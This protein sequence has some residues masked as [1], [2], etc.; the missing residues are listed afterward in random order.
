[1]PISAQLR[2]FGKIHT[3]SLLA[4]LLEEGWLE[5]RPSVWE[6]YTAKTEALL[7]QF[8]KLPDYQNAISGNT[9]INC[10]DHWAQELIETGYLHN[11]A[12]MWFSSIWI[13][14]LKLPW[15]LGA[16]FF[17][18]HLLDG[19]PA[20]N[21]LSWRWTAGL[22]T[23]GKHYIARAENIEKFT[24]GKF[25]PIGQLNE[26]PEAIV[27]NFE[28]PKPIWHKSQ[29]VEKPAHAV[30]LIITEE[31]V[32]P[33]EYPDW[34]FD[35]LI[36]FQNVTANEDLQISEKVLK[37]RKDCLLEACELIREQ[38]DISAHIHCAA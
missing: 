19:D 4:H 12:R 30:T 22:Q 6:D 3:R 24:Q 11:H 13:F 26:T 23:V 31:D 15:Q 10:F 1:M 27:D 9:G 14:T 5:M 35:S 29:T 21:T 16:H 25:N 18:S 17:L 33:S 2:I 8:E 36:S 28:N 20:S 7:K 32:N 34:N 38:K 37:H